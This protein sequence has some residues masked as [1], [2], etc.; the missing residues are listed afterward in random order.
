MES[1]WY[2]VTKPLAIGCTRS[3]ISKRLHQTSMVFLLSSWRKDHKPMQYVAKE[4]T[5]KWKDLLISYK[6]SHCECNIIQPISFFRHV[7]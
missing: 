5:Y 3:T 1:K 2:P 7:S 6:H 4:I